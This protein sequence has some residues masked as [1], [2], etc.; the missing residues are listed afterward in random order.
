MCARNYDKVADMELSEPA[1]C[2]LSGHLELE[3]AMEYLLKKLEAAGKL[4]DTVI[5][6]TP[7]HYPYGLTI[8]EYSEIVGHPVDPIFEKFENAFICYSADMESVPVD[9]YCCTIDILP[10]LLNLFGI[11]FDSRLLPGVDVFAP[12]DYHM[13]VL[14]NPS[15]VDAKGEFNA[16]KKKTN[17]K[18]G[19]SVQ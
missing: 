9:T 16:A 11:E 8:E 6:M 2:Y 15:F 5:V 7:D 1:K 18:N 13:A 3:Y 19:A 10:T 12:S 17:V 14:S 4:S